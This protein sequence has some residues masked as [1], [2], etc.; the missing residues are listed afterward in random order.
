MKVKFGSVG[1]EKWVTSKL[2]WSRLLLVN[3][4]ERGCQKIFKEKASSDD[5]GGIYK[6][7]NIQLLQIS[8]A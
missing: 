4:L 6:I 7:E 3:T 5:W 1:R 8:F 2:P